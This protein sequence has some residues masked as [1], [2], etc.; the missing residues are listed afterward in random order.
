MMSKEALLLEAKTHYHKP[1]ILEKVYRL[2]SA[3]EQF[4]SIPYLRN[5]LVLKGGTEEGVVT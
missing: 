3:L 2:L 1:K 4:M 5:R